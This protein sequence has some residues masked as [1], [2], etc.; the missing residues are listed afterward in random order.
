MELSILIARIISVIYVSTGIAVIIGTVDFNRIVDGLKTS[1]ALTFIAGATAIIG[2]IFLIE[3]H[4]LWVKNWTVLITIIS[5][6]LLI[7]GIV[8]LIFPKFLS[9]YNQLLKNSRLLGSFILIFGLIMGYFG[10]II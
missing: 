4:N 1:P 10:F 3:Y 6:F 2:G 8:V 7:G 5:W 9:Y